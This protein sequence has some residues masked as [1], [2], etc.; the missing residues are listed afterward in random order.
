MIIRILISIL[1]LQLSIFGQTLVANYSDVTTAADGANIDNLVSSVR[2]NQGSRGLVLIYSGNDVEL[3]GNVLGYKSR[4][5][6][7]IRTRTNNWNNEDPTIAV[8]IVGGGVRFQRSLWLKKNGDPYPDFE[9][10]DFD[11]STLDRRILYA[12]NECKECAPGE[13]DI[14]QFDWD[15]IIDLLKENP[16][17]MAEFEIV[18][19]AIYT[20]WDEERN[21]SQMT[22]DRYLQVLKSWFE[23]E[24]DIE[25]AQ[26]KFRLVDGPN[27]RIFLAP[28]PK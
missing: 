23:G 25:T 16:K 7:Y 28:G 14:W 27:E 17:V 10:L 2:E 15:K 5:E 1:L 12:S 22:P 20:S 8:R 6:T 11:L 9:P 24:S 13:L 19:N 26:I 4:V 21:T 3:L 18:I